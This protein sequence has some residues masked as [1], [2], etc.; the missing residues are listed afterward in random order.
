PGWSQSLQPLD[1]AAKI[2]I[3][4]VAVLAER[5]SNDVA[6][7]ILRAAATSL[8]KRSARTA[9]L[10]M[11]IFAAASSGCRLCDQPCRP[12][13]SASTLAS[14]AENDRDEEI[15]LPRL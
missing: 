9:T 6:P 4:S 7:S 3:P 13:P 14:S 8:E 2:G 12:R 11:P 5:F 10:G 15:A 1:A